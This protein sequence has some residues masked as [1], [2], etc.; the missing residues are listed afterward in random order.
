MGQARVRFA[1]SPTGYL[2]VGSARTALF[3]WLFARHVGGEFILRIEDTDRARSKDEFLEEILDSLK[4]LGMDWD[5]E[6]HFQSKRMD[7]YNR[8]AKKLLD[9]GFAYESEGAVHFK[10]P[11]KRL[12]IPDLIHGDIEFN[13]SLIKDQVLIKS[14]GTPTYNFA[15]VVDDADMKMTHIIRGDDHISNTPKQVVIYNALG[16]DLP[17]FCHIPLILGVD[18][19]R[20]SK[21]HG[22]TSIRDY[23]E[24]GFLPE[25]LVNYLCLLGWSPGT[26]REILPIQEVVKEFT[27]ENI[28]KTAAVFDINKLLWMNGEYIRGMD[29]DK[30]TGLVIDVLRKENL[31]RDEFEKKWFSGIVKLFQERIKTIYD[32]IELTDFFFKDD[33]E[34]DPEGV[35]KFFTPDSKKIFPKLTEKLKALEKFDTE[36]IENA[37]RSLADELGVKAAKIIHPVRLAATGKTGGAGLFETLALLGKEKTIERLSCAINKYMN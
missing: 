31:L 37:V 12:K 16:I 26:D 34:Y 19:S 15:V 29:V 25:A 11:Q 24:E 35:K 33:I 10:M 7:L 20:L 32:F 30:L 23:R 8:Y 27:L 18:R 17:V 9:D 5:G 14:D 21:R 28:N 6:V 36:S 4:W 2:H 1:P 3:N 22:A 13:A